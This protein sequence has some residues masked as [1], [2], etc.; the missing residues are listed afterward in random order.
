MDATEIRNHIFGVDPNTDWTGKISKPAGLAPIANKLPSPVRSFLT[1]YM[2]SHEYKDRV[3]EFHF[4]KD[5]KDR[6]RWKDQNIKYEPV[7]VTV[8]TVVVCGGHVLVV[9]RKFNP[10]QGLYALPGGFI[11][12]N[13]RIED[14]ALRELKEETGI[15]VDKLILQSNI[16][17]S[18]V[19]DYPSRSLRGRTIT[20]AYFIKLKDG[21]LPEVRGND[22]AAVARWIPIMDVMRSEEKFFEDHAHIIN[23][24]LTRS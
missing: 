2:D 19:F 16:V 4:L 12:G 11:K 6:H 24:F 22:D 13:E 3:E 21:R 14:A 1:S 15:R 17:D 23:Y 7:F 10:G 18:H 20:H 5:Y 8:D 9:K